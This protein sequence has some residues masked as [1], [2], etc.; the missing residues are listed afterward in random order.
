MRTI[1]GKMLTGFCL[2]LLLLLSLLGVVF[3]LQVS[4]TA[5][6]LTENLSQEAL[7]A[8]SAEI[9]R[10]M[11]GYRDEIRAI[12]GRRIIRE[13][14]FDEI[15]DEMDGLAGDLNKDFEMIFYVDVE[16]RFITT[17]GAEGNVADR[18]YFK[19]IM[20]DG[21][22]ETIS[23]PVVSRA[24]GEYVFVVA[25]EVVNEKGRRTGLAAAAVQLR[26]LSGIAGAIRLGEKGF[27]Y[28]VDHN[29]LLIAHPSYSLRMKLNLLQS[30]KLGYKGL[31]KIGRLMA[32]GRP[33]VL[34]YTRPNGVTLIT[35]FN[36][37]PN[38]P[39]WALGV[40]MYE[41]ELMGPA[42]RLTRNLVV[43]MLGIFLIVVLIGY[44]M[45][46]H[47]AAPIRLLKAG[48][49]HISSGDLERRLEIH[50]GDEI[51]ALADSFNAMTDALKEHIRNL[52]VTT[53]EKAS[54]E[55]ELRVA[56]NIQ[57]SMLPRSFPP[58]PEMEHLDLYAAMEPARN[59]GGDFYDF[60]LLDDH[61]L[62]FSIGDVSGKGVPAALFMVITRTILKNLVMQGYSLS[63]AFRLANNMLCHENTECMFVTAFMAILDIDKGTVEH[64]NAG[65]NPPLLSRGG[66]DFECLEVR[67]DF[68]LGGM[69]DT[70]YIRLTT[71]IKPGD[72]FF[73]YTDGVT[74]AMNSRNELFSDERLVETLNRLHGKN[75]R[76]VIAGV[77][78]EIDRFVGD[79]P[80]SDDVTM[81]AFTLSEL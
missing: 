12:A 3:Y 65:H 67:R 63:E 68:V 36:P 35:I 4:N 56:N 22:R 79:T 62:C 52:E 72:V 7:K 59:V 53:A 14:T 78:E 29:G 18:A 76:F 44:V 34:P 1:R 46:G 27:G 33:G 25:H 26:T 16:G 31:E 5:V 21:R 19:D 64:V 47:I 43:F 49:D 23:D 75:P 2:P 10:I 50:T 39:S 8:R 57:A 9:G 48:A 70:E 42:D 77:R 61:R 13:G 28:I 71:E 20:F 73:I 37:I 74:E 58:F 60:F 17:T 30:D 54:I 51:E 45:S 15:R 80:A 6:S 32:D 55:S 81:L 38:A 69:D 41:D 11:A 40:S 66:G 24:S